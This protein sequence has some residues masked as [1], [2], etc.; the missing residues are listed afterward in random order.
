MRGAAGA[1]PLRQHLHHH[2]ASALGAV[3]RRF[4]G[5]RSPAG[6]V[7]VTLVRHG[8]TAAGTVLRC[9]GGRRCGIYGVVGHS[10]MVA[11]PPPHG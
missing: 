3:A 9:G 11:D 2:A 10:S 8:L 4:E 6:I 1:P 5:Q 7:T